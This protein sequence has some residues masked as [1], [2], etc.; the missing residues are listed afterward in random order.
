MDKETRFNKSQNYIFSFFK[1]IIIIVITLL[2]RPVMLGLRWI[3][4]IDMFFRDSFIIIVI[5]FLVP[6]IINDVIRLF[7]REY[8]PYEQ[9]RKIYKDEINKANTAMDI[10][11]IN[12]NE[13]TD[14]YVINKKQAKTAFTSAIIAGVIGFILIC[15]GIILLYTKEKS[16]LNAALVSVAGAICEVVASLFLVVYNKT[17]SQI[18]IFYKSLNQ[19]EKFLSIIE[20]ARDLGEKRDEIFIKIIENSLINS[21]D[22][23]E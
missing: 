17:I 20:L 23:I 11:K 16:S 6:F 7:K 13:I 4:P 10:M 14:Y 1:Y 15:I 21:K 9:N 12:L 18:N 22:D 5:L 8:V 19:K 2:I 3:E